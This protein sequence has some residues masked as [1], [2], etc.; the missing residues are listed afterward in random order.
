M[1]INLILSVDEINVLLGAL[2]VGLVE[3]IKN[4]AMA[5]IQAQQAPVVVEPVAE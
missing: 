3:K 5:Q 4:Q 2:N 1:E